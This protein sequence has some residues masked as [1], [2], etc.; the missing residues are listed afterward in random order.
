[1]IEVTAMQKNGLP[2]MQKIN[3][4]NLNGKITDKSTGSSQSGQVE[5][6]N[7]EHNTK[8][9]ALGPNTKR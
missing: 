7:Q 4:E 3:M 8:K 5:N 1:M 6:Q 2:A 9:V